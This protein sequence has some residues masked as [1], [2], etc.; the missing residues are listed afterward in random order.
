MVA[1]VSD[2]KLLHTC[3]QPNPTDLTVTV[4]ILKIM[5]ETHDISE[6]VLKKQVTC[7]VSR[8]AEITVRSI[9]ENGGICP[10]CQST[11]RVKIIEDVVV[12]ISPL[13]SSKGSVES[14][15]VPESPVAR[16]ERFVSEYG[17]GSETADKLTTDIRVADF[18]EKVAEES[19]PKTASTFVV[20]TLL[21]ELHY[22]DMDVSSVEPSDVI[23]VVTALSEDNVTWKA[24]TEE[25]IREAL[26]SG[27]SID[28]V[29]S[30]K[31][32]EKTTSDELEKAVTSVIEEETEAVE[33]YQSG[34]DEALNHL[35]GMVMKETGGTADAEKARELLVEKT[36]G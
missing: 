34:T 21:G 12:P 4:I 35:V 29:F 18:Y 16:R 5:I 10:S 3:F 6:S 33:D 14:V 28:E 17:V 11:I 27:E 22:R 8:C 7:P 32:I 1:N 20:D 15:S 30:T 9:A 19:D 25:V 24:V 26:D 31:D 2:S 36:S 13:D 23:D